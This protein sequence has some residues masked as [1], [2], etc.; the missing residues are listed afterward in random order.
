MTRVLL[1]GPL[2]P[3]LV[4]TV[5]TS[6]GAATL[7]DGPEQA[8]FLAEHADSVEVVVTSGRSGVPTDLMQALPAPAGGGQLRRRLRHHGHHARP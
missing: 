7:P 3:S 6:Y 8:A 2:K 4:E 1:A 5:T